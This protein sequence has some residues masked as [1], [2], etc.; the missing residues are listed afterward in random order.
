MSIYIH[1]MYM[2]LVLSCFICLFSSYSSRS[3]VAST[4]SWFKIF[5]FFHFFSPYTSHESPDYTEMRFIAFVLLLFH[6]FRLQYT[7]CT[8]HTY[9]TQYVQRTHYPWIGRSIL[10]KFFVIVAV[11]PFSYI[12]LILTKD[13]FSFRYTIRN[14]SRTLRR[15]EMRFWC[16]TC[17]WIKYLGVLVWDGKMETQTIFNFQLV[18]LEGKERSVLFLHTRP[19]LSRRE[20]GYFVVIFS[21]R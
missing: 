7:I 13:Q 15:C 1:D 20:K 18:V 8:M 17:V 4:F 5:F 12:I 3:F 6:C 11:V 19:I 14:V 16:F 2:Q 21:I 10:Q 9:A